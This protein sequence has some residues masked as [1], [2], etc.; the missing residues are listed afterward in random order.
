MTEIAENDFRISHVNLHYRDAADGPLAA[1]ILETLG[2]TRTQELAFDDGNIFYRFT[3]HNRDT[4][5]PDGIVYLSK[6]PEVLADLVHHSRAALSADS[7]DPH[8]SVVA[9]RL[10]QDEDPELNFHIG[11]LIGSLEMLEERIQKLQELE[12]SDPRFMGRMKFVFNRP[13]RQHEKEDARLDSSPVFGKTDRYTFGYHGVQA[14]IVTNL[15]VSGPLA[16]AMSFELDY[17]FPGHE[18]HILAVS[19]MTRDEQ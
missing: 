6:L 15:V 12:C 13:P 8:D 11:F 3:I 17:I 5:R 7:S 9:A 1:E 10:A 14:F 18:N 4:N 16:E 2:L 19:E